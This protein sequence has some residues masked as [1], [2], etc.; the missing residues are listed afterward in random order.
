MP[1]DFIRQA[2]AIPVK[3]GRICL[4]TNSSGKRWIIPKGMIETG[5]TPGETALRETWEEAG[6]VGVLRPEPVGS[7]LYEKYGGICHVTVFLMQVSSVAQW[8]PER[9]IRRRSWF[10]LDGVMDRITEDG[11]SEIIQAAFD[12]EAI[13]SLS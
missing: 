4:I 12:E 3:S 5:H 10:S 2:A 6:L 7:Y 9:H 8:W 13:E 11:L 1:S